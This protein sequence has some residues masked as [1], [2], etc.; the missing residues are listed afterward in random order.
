MLTFVLSLLGFA[1]RYA[2]S[3]SADEDTVV[4]GT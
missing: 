1:G 2:A 3:A 4:W